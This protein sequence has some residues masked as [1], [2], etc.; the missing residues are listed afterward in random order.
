MS[1]KL[2]RLD[3]MGCAYFKFKLSWFIENVDKS[4]QNVMIEG[5]QNGLFQQID[6]FFEKRRKF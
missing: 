6:K 5:N 4:H 1:N 2:K 3:E